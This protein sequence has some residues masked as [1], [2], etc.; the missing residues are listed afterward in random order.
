MFILLSY[1]DS[2][3]TTQPTTADSTQNNESPNDSNVEQILEP[4]T[5]V[6]I[7]GINEQPS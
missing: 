1:Y 5:W 7:G 4:E 2:L 3:F 6:E